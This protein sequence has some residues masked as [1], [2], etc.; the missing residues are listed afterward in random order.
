[1]RKRHLGKTDIQVSEISFGTVSLGIPYGIGI[2]KNDNMIS[3][4]DAIKLL[5]MALDNGI[6]FYDTA[7]AYGLSE[8]RI[9]KA[10]KER[11]Q[12]VIIAT[13]CKHLCDSKGQLPK[14]TEIKKE[15]ENSMNDSLSALQTDY[16]DVFMMHDGN[17]DTITNETVA[18]TLSEFKDKGLIRSTGISTYTVEET[19]KAIESGLWDIIELAYNL[20]DQRQGELF[21]LAEQKGVGIV[22]R[23]AL[24]KGILTERGNHLHEELKEVK[25]HRETY[26]ELLDNDIPKLS[27][28]AI[29]FV[30][31]NREVSSALIGIDK[32]EYLQNALSVAD[33]NYL[34]DKKLNRAKQLAYPE[35]EFLDLPMWNKKG[36]LI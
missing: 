25:N 24:F 22:V 17:I 33:G 29:K 4:E 3:G 30:L 13:K 2:K 16:I 36:W 26:N 15:I 21:S 23:S 18:K 9:G 32:P 5:Q 10:F 14:D 19:K 20:M 28:L 34:G 6:N 12:D 11:R 31:S 1:M 8:E 27:S 35:P 7:R